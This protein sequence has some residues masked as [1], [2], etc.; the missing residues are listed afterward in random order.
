MKRFFLSTYFFLL[1][2]FCIT[3]FGVDLAATYYLEKKYNEIVLELNEEL[4]RGT[5]YLLEKEFQQRG[6]QSYQEII[7]QL[8]PEFGYPLK[9]QRLSDLEFTSKEEKILQRKGVIIREDGDLHLRQIGESDYVVSMGPFK[10]ID[11]KPLETTSLFILGAII[12]GLLI[13]LWTVF[14]W[15][16][17]LKISKA[18]DAFG[19]GDFSA[20]AVVSKFSSISAIARNFNEMAEQIE[21]LIS[22]HK[23]LV[24][25]VSHEL[26][27]PISRIRFGLE[28]V[29]TAPEIDR[30][31]HLKG[32]RHDVDELDELVNELLSYS[33]FERMEN[34][35]E[36]S[37]KPLLPWLHEYLTLVHESIDTEIEFI[38]RDIDLDTLVCFDP[39]QLE[40]ALHN[41]LQNGSRYSNGKMQIV[42]KKEAQC[43]AISVGDDGPGIP[44]E[45][46][47]RIFEPFVRLDSSRN[48]ERGG[49]G[50]GLAIVREIVRNHN[51]H[52]K[53]GRSSLGGALI[54]LEIPLALS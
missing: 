53:V 3:I 9:L 42:L 37:P 32:I 29:R 18:V 49:Y 24:N 50:L 48:R 13:F 51:G 36:V 10:D 54:T 19:Q 39:R 12:F 52:L 21:R 5:F 14:F 2:A 38:G 46:R 15:Q 41:L 16:K 45:D 26:R 8:Q 28:S 11:L 1:L 30:D 43:I 6:N 44:E 35:F 7:D 47:V 17:L 4:S 22:S 25:S 31:K 27:T 33:R 34:S 40:R 23:Q 20:R